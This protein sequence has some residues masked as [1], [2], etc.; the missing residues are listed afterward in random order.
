MKW[1]R[2]CRQEHDPLPARDRLA[3]PLTPQEVKVLVTAL[4][5]DDRLTRIHRPDISGGSGFARHEADAILRTAGI[6]ASIRV[7]R[8]A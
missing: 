8:N 5:E 6:R 7:S 1:L 3:V 2:R 4:Q